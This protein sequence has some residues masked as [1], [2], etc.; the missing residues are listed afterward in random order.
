MKKHNLL[1]ATLLSALMLSIACDSST[2]KTAVL[3]DDVPEV[4]IM[5]GMEKLSCGYGYEGIRASN[6]DALQNFL[7]AFEEGGTITTGDSTWL[8]KGN[9]YQKDFITDDWRGKH[10]LTVVL[11]GANQPLVVEHIAALRGEEPVT[12]SYAADQCEISYYTPQ[13]NIL[14]KMKKMSCGF[15]YEGFGASYLD[16]MDTFLFTYDQDTITPENRLWTMN[17]NTYQ[18]IFETNDWRGKHTLTVVLD[19][20]GQIA[21]AEHL[22]QLPDE[23]PQTEKFSAEECSLTLY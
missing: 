16:M 10:V 6:L 8:K 17:G 2:E 14:N 15:G 9:W 20:A 7:F 3:S 5:N 22:S 13:V 1:S 18:K 11:D 23:D 21:E 19:D 12:T 4:N